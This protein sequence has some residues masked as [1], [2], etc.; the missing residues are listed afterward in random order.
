LPA[1]AGEAIT[2]YLAGGRP[3]PFEA[4]RQVFLRVRAP[5]R[6]LT[7]GGV[8]QAVFAAGQRTGIG[9]VYAHQLRHSAATGILAPGHR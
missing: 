2:A 4:V 9:P 8:T 7:S 1:D 3:E 5:H 6:G